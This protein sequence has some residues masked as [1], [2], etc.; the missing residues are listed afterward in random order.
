MIG[1]TPSFQW[2]RLTDLV[3]FL[4]SLCSCFSWSCDSHS[5]PFSELSASE[6]KEDDLPVRSIDPSDGNCNNNN[7]NEIAKKSMRANANTTLACSNGLSII[8]L[9]FGGQ[10]ERVRASPVLRASQCWWGGLV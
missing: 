8:I 4:A 5:S 2:V 1:L 3:Y 9:K 7:N 6:A 10:R